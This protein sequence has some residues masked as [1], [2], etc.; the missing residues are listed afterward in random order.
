MDLD[1]L[2]RVP[3]FE[4]LS[5]AQ[6][7]KVAEVCEPERFRRGTHVFRE[8]ETGSTMFVLVEGK[9]RISRQ[10]PGMGEEALAILAPGAAFGEMAVVEEAPRSAD[11]IA[12]E[13]V[14]LLRIER[15]R[16]DQ[17]LFTD[18]ELAYAVLWALVRTLS[19]RLR[20][21]NEKM[22]AFFAMSKF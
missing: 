12:H 14:T 4:G 20:E 5:Q 13:D 17:L 6:L 16:L 7:R 18:K 21:T 3:L 1:L 2:G 15:D 10:V 22:K 9:I 11:A 8:G 19:G